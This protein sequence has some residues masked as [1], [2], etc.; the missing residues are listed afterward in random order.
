MENKTATVTQGTSA[1]RG[2]RRK[3]EQAE[4]PGCGARNARTAHRCRICTKVINARVGEQQRGLSALHPDV[5]AGATFGASWGRN[6]SSGAPSDVSADG[7]AGLP[8]S[9][10][11]G[12]QSVPLAAPPP[13]WEPSPD[14]ELHELAAAIVLDAPL[15]N[16]PTPPPIEHA[17]EPFD[18][19]ALV[20]E[21][22]VPGT[23]ARG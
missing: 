11:R 9:P 6:G 4:C 5:G 16:G 17:E 18:P 14:D 7:A 19:T 3:G 23:V 1:R 22:G 15:R 12:W 13:Q 2:A 8:A 20:R 10:A 21:L